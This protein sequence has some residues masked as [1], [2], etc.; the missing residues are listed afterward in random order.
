MTLDQFLER[1]VEGYL[2]GDLRTMAAIKIPADEPF[3]AVGYPMVSSTLAGVEL[4]GV[5]TADKIFNPTEGALRFEEFWTGFLYRGQ[6]DRQPM[7]SLVYKLVRH[8]LAHT[9]M[10]KPVFV[11]VKERHP[12]HL[13][14]TTEGIVI[15]AL[16]LADDLIAAYR[17]SVK[18]QL[19]NDRQ[20]RERVELRFKNVR[21]KYTS[22]FNDFRD[23]IAKVPT[24]PARFTSLPTSPSMNAAFSTNVSSRSSE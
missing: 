4:L 8:G 11:V 22:D 14:R 10:T 2:F 13:C 21:D 18:P 7:A 6:P 23:V 24:R 16:T 9:F 19:Q 3:G 5:L 1:F 17:L 20:F 12:F 15:D